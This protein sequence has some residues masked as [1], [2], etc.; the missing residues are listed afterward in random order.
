MP[1]NVVDCNALKTYVVKKFHR[2][3]NVL[4][5]III[6][7]NMSR[8]EMLNWRIP[9]LPSGGGS[10]QPSFVFNLPPSE[11]DSLA[12]VI[13]RNEEWE[14]KQAFGAAWRGI[15]FNIRTHPII[16]VYRASIFP[17]IPGS[18]V[19]ELRQYALEHREYVHAPEY[20]LYS[21]SVPIT[22][23]QW[24]EDTHEFVYAPTLQEWEEI[25]K[26][27]MNTI[28][29]EIRSLILECSQKN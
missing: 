21:L 15:I 29:P 4:R 27:R 23:L 10:W 3:L 19:T 2:P 25:T 11:K 17:I 22:S 13:R 14:L 20:K 28:P 12:D 5:Q 7:G 9:Q 24:I 1:T 18:Y 26:R 8:S 6:E 16:M